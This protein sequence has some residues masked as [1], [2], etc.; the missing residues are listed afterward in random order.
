VRLPSLRGWR[1]RAG[2]PEADP[3]FD[4]S[5]WTVADRTTTVS[6]IKPKT[7]PVL[8]ADDY[9]FH[10]GNL[11][12]RGRFTPT[13][14]ETAVALNAITGKRGNYLVWLNG[15]YLG[16][17]A[18]GVQADADAPVNPDPG[19][20]TFA[21]PPGL[22]AAGRPAVLSVLVQNM[23]HNDDWTAEDNRHKQPRGLFGAALIEGSP[24]S[25]P[26]AAGPSATGSPISWRIQGAAG[27]EDPSDRV[28][29]PLNTGGL[30][31][32]R[33]GWHLPGYPDRSWRPAAT[34]GAGRAGVDW[35]RTTFRLD[36]PAG[37]DVP[38][39]LRFTRAPSSGHRVLIFLNGWNVGQYGGD[40]G[41]QTEFYLPG[42]LL[43]ERGD[44]TLALAVTA[45]EAEP[46]G[47]VPVEL[48]AYAN[49]RGGVHVRDVRSP[50]FAPPDGAAPGALTLPPAD[51]A[52][53]GAPPSKEIR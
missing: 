1:H 9:G 46:G 8:Y 31:G 19:P 43:R 36:L 12:Y 50:G 28:R 5:R 33:A 26:R 49:A 44:N 37:H 35:Y 14:T 25:G 24:A 21:I 29:G 23:G 48:F 41:P 6:P 3:G 42:G 18:G 15:R 38:V 40:I 11:W 20:G 2:A 22:L 4:D 10:H 39:G 45:Q 16:R 51:G 30:Y 27:G 32:E 17:A 7:P 52:A 53:P 34:P 47:P 13:G